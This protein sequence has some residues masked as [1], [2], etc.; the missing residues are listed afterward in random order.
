MGSPA[1]TPHKGFPAGGGG[2]ESG[3]VLPLD[4]IKKEISRF[5]DD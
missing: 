1:C 2:T 5:N 3:A 4:K